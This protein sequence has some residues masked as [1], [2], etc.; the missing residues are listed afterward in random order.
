MGTTTIEVTDE[1]KE[2]LEAL[3]RADR[4]AMKT[5]VG[6]V[7]DAYEGDDSGADIEPTIRPTVDGEALADLREQIQGELSDI[8]DGLLLVEDA[9]AAD[10]EDLRQS[11][12]TVEER[13]GR[14]ERTL[15]DLQ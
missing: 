14:I 2:R 5:V 7:L 12:A 8:P 6:R 15:E 13:T 3:K 4:E 10:L 1:Q 11:L 9:D